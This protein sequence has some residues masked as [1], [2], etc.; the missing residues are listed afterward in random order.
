L[1][2]QEATAGV[3]LNFFCCKSVRNKGDQKSISKMIVATTTQNEIDGQTVDS[4]PPFVDVATNSNSFI[5]DPVE[6]PRGRYAPA[7]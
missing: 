1:L 4:A 7:N 6:F 5:V 2:L 3:V